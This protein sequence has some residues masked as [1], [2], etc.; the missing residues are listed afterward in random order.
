MFLNIINILSY[1]IF[2]SLIGYY[3]IT[4]LQ[5]YSYK[6]ERAILHHTKPM[7]NYIYFLAPFLTYDFVMLVSHHRYGWIVALVY[8]GLFYYWFRG[9]DKR[10]V[11]TGRV[12][13][14]FASLF[15]VAI[16]LV[17]IFKIYSIFIPIIIAWLIS[18]SI[19]KI[20]FNGYK[21]RAKKK[22]DS[23]RDMKVVGVTASYGKTSIKNFVDTLL[24]LKYKTYATP[25]SVN[26]LGGVIK[27]I[28]EDL[29]NNTEVYIVEMGAREVGDIL[30]ITELVNPH[31]AIVGKIGPAHIEYFK[32]LE[33]IRDTKMEIIHSNRLIKAWVDKSANIK[34][35]ERVVS[36]GDEVEDIETSLEGI[37][38][39]MNGKRYSAPILG[40][41][42]AYNIAMAIS[43]A[44]EMGLSDKEIDRGLKELKPVPHRLQRIDAGGK[45]ILDDSFNGN[46][47]GM[48]EAFKIASLHNGRRVVITPGLVEATEELNKEVAK[49]ADS[50][51]DLVV[52]TG[53]L[54]YDIFKEIVSDKKLIHL[55]DKSTLQDFLAKNTK[56][57]DLILFANDAPSFI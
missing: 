56:A 41:F 27:D 48:R 43:L 21:L 16:F 26:T 12:K 42:N 47:E 37:S 57:G 53:D 33:R 49:L 5:W 52:V 30:E 40:S 50:I 24:N 44:K 14:F 31:Y 28:N 9:V 2:L 55:Q 19:E 17:L 18:L 54:N 46:I 11:F 4:T 45:I 32:T 51:F 39:T 36:F 35:D 6:L 8:I 3:F 10:L 38:F 13:R 20:L 34:G 22:L 15:F 1:F 25:R 7:W 23:M 29:P